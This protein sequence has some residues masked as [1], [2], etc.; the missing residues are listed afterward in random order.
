M[1]IAMR[2]R[3]IRRQKKMSQAEFS[4]GAGL[5]Q[6]SVS[7]YESGRRIPEAE[8]IKKICSAYNVDLNW[9]MT[10]EGHPYN[11]ARRRTAKA[12]DI[13]RL[14][15]VAD[16]AAGAGIEA[17]DIEPEEYLVLHPSIMPAPGPYFAFRVQGESMTPH[18]QSG[19]YAIVTTSWQ[20]MDI[21]DQICAVRTHEGLTLKRYIIDSMRRMAVL[22]PLNPVYPTIRIEEDDPD[23]VIVGVLLLIIRKCLR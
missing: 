7:H 22:Y 23:Y 6:S 8:A 21:N 17:F 13:L 3:E 16:I 10:G 20:E 18:I 14:P 11:T 19:D 1:A 5:T 12:E 15:V 4:A 9:L 2:I